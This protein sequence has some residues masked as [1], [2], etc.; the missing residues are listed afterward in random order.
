LPA[1]KALST[2]RHIAVNQT[3][4]IM[5]CPRPVAEINLRIDSGG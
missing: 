3:V 4:L 2:A 1:A 5:L